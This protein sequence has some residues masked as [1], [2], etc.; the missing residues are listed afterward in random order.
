MANLPKRGAHS[1]KRGLVLVVQTELSPR[2]GGHFFVLPVAAQG[3][4][5]KERV[6]T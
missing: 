3:C 1:G 6:T 4:A 5:T 2:A